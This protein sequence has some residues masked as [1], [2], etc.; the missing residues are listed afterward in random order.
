MVTTRTF[1]L[2]SIALDV[3]NSMPTNR[4]YYVT[5]QSAPRETGRPCGI[6]LVGRLP[7]VGVGRGTALNGAS[8]NT[9]VLRIP[10]PGMKGGRRQLHHARGNRGEE[11]LFLLMLMSS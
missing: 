3:A 8:P 2:T 1:V 11:R 4:G 9:S 7:A 10:L 6:L 5:F